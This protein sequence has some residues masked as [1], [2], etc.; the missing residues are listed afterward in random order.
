MTTSARARAT[1]R[2]P[3][4]HKY[5]LRARPLRPGVAL[6]DT[7]RFRDDRWP[8]RA[9]FLQQSH[10]ALTLNF[11]AIPTCHRPAAK[12]LCYAMLSGPLP[13]GEPRPALP[14]IHAV[15]GALA[16]FL[17]WLDTRAR[18]PGRPSRL[19]LTDLVGADLQAYQ[20]HLLSA[21]PGRATR[22]LRR[23]A[24]RYLWRY[25]NAITSDRLLF[26]PTH[27]DGWLER[28]A[29]RST[30]NATD[31]IPE[32]VH[33]PLLAWA[34]RFIDDFAEDILAA[35]QQWCALR[36]PARRRPVGRRPGSGPG[37][38]DQL[39]TLLDD[40]LAQKR[41]L[42]GYRGRPN[43]WFLAATLGC[44]TSTLVR[45]KADIASV[46]AIV[47]VS[48]S[49]YF[50]RA[51]TGQLDNKPWVE[52]IVTDHTFHNGLATL[53]RMLHVSCYIAVAFL[54]GMR[55][56]EVKHLRRGC[57][58][59]RRDSNGRAYRWTVT[60]LAF[61][62]EQGPHGVNATWVIGAPAARAIQVLQRLQPAHVNLLFTPLSQAP[63][64]GGKKAT[65]DT[66]SA[67]GYGSTNAHLN[68]FITWINNHCATHGRSD[69]IPL[70]NNHV[71]KLSTRQFRRTLAWFIARRPGGVIAGAIAYRHLSI[72][73]FEGYAGTSE[74]GFRAEVESEQA[75]ARGEHLLAMIDAHEHNNLAGPAA[76]DAAHRLEEFGAHA[77]FHGKVIT[78]QRRLQRLMNRDD[79]AIYP[80]KYITCVHKHATALCLQR[81]DSRGELRP[82]LGACLPLACRNVAL[83]PDNLAAW[84]TELDHIDTELTAR[85]LLPPLLRHQL[86]TRRHD[87]VTFLDRHTAEHS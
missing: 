42:P 86:Q 36:D 45:F 20:R 16:P 26:D 2:H 79:P 40:H 24:V 30:E 84:R 19:A 35:D 9:A 25:R 52:G 27:V 85:P 1:A 31:R 83:S 50:D 29:R 21:V 80:D 55:D 57:L 34:V 44:A 28:R 65:D 13:P 47:G 87:I 4:D 56:T 62:G 17:T 6:A 61:K 37:V 51:I 12:E 15:L 77:R 11:T 46:A 60:S 58:T 49:A 81:R 69:S 53:A 39:R 71:W 8:L 72:Q 66:S 68:E 32:S 78:D 14:T 67:L 64:P 76:D 5:V 18:Q 82:D 75:L 74:S 73:M 23:G 43:L 38:R 54:S 10:R 63:G 22:D 70:V 7:A 3:L 41:P 59:V 48:D 33:G